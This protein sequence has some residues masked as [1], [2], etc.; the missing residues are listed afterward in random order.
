VIRPE[1]RQALEMQHKVLVSLW[2]FFLTGILLY[3]WIAETFLAARQ[4]TIG[5]AFAQ[6]TRLFLW[7]LTLVDIATLFWW[8][9][10]FLTPEAIVNGAKRYKLLQALQDHKGAA[11]ERAGAVITSYVTGKIVAFALA[12]AVAIYG[13]A[14]VLT[15]RYFVG[16][17][18]LSAGSALLLVMEFPSRRVLNELIGAAEAE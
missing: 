1:Y 15:S 14:L 17:Y 5:P 2:A 3:L 4:L 13:F 16:L 7:C 8:K 9:R 11:E 18:I 10:R 12:E 6:A